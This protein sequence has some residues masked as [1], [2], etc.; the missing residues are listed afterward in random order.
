MSPTRFEEGSFNGRSD[1][2]KRAPRPR[3]V[4]HVPSQAAN[5]DDVAAKLEAI[6]DGIVEKHK[7][8]YSHHKSNQ[9]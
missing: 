5:R 1:P 2:G 6:L 9:R 8:R 7:A 4:V 3:Q